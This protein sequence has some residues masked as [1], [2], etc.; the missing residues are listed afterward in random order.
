MG[1]SRTQTRR[2]RRER[3]VISR[4]EVVARRVIA[5]VSIDGKMKGKKKRSRNITIH[6]PS[7]R[8]MYRPLSC[9]IHC[10]I[11]F[12]LFLFEDLE[13]SMVTP[14]KHR[15]RT[16]QRNSPQESKLDIIHPAIFILF[17]CKSKLYLCV[18]LVVQNRPG[19]IIS[20]VPL[21]DPMFSPRP[22][23]IKGG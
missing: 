15:R 12:V 10:T 7:D 20:M 3:E 22:S 17:S 14:G 1:G 21:L 8:R 19:Q 4:H 13:L 11:S 5:E 18:R 23:S 16:I 6:A 9:F 2:R